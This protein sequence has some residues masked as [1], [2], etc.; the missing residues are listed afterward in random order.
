MD[1]A[2]I[3]LSVSLS[4]CH[5]GGLSSDRNRLISPGK[6]LKATNITWLYSQNFVTKLTY[7]LQISCSIKTIGWVDYNMLP[8]VHVVYES[9]LPAAPPAGLPQS[10]QSVYA[11]S[12]DSSWSY[13][14][15]VKNQLNLMMHTAFTQTDLHVALMASYYE[16]K[17]LKFVTFCKSIYFFLSQQWLMVNGNQ[18]VCQLFEKHQRVTS[19]LK[20]YWRRFSAVLVFYLVSV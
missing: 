10:C 17:L 7:L 11:V 16:V 20:F 9:E 14:F 15:H 5:T 6:F 13:W 1:R 4:V 18:N 19:C 3:T 12:N 2:N 8:I